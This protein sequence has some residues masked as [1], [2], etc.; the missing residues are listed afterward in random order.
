MAG[1]KHKGN[2]KKGSNQDIVKSE[3]EARGMK[4]DMGSGKPVDFGKRPPVMNENSA[5]VAKKYGATM[6]VKSGGSSGS[7]PTSPMSKEKQSSVPG[8]K[9]ERDQGHSWSSAEGWTK[10]GK[11]RDNNR[12]RN[13]NSHHGSEPIS[14]TLELRGCPKLRG[15]T[16]I[17][18]VG[19]GGKDSGT[20][21]VK[22]VVHK[23]GKGKMFTTTAHVIRAG[24][25]KGG[26]GGQPPM[27]MYTDI[28]NK[29]KVYMGPRKI[30]QGA[31]VT[32]TRGD[33]YFRD[34]RVQERVQRQRGGG[35][36]EKGKG[37]G[38]DIR[39][40]LKPIDV[41]PASSGGFAGNSVGGGT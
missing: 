16:T 6:G 29:G 30:N 4:P 28:W 9:M 12:S 32:I 26:T 41:G 2:H 40:E 22:R 21:Y 27:V 23:G 14:G 38:L 10:D 3:L 5:Q 39:S 18:I 36:P 25:G 8:T 1:G 20:W 31:S 17:S 35:E 13:A 34:F 24:S 7:Q 11:G 15:K 37:K 33:G 19:V